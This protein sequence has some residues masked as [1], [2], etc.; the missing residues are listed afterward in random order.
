MTAIIEIVLKYHVALV[1]HN[2]ILLVYNT[3]LLCSSSFC[4]IAII[5]DSHTLLHYRIILVMQAQVLL[6]MLLDETAFQYHDSF[7]I[8]SMQLVFHFVKLQ[9]THDLI[10]ML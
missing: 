4:S 2:V 5:I 8:I 1:G 3:F 7:L 9:M 6:E 10:L